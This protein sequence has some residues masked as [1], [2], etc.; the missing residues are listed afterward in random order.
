MT[1]FTEI[2]PAEIRHNPFQLIGREWMLITAGTI[3]GFNTMTAN[4][5]TWGYL[6]NRDVD[7]LLCAP[8][9]PHVRIHGA[10]R[11]VH[12][13]LL[14]GGVAEGAGVLRSHSGRDVDKTGADGADPIRDAGRRG[15]A[16]SRRGWCWSAG[17]CMR[18]T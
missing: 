6:W 14:R 4:W 10:E 7:D 15:R 9:A 11:R 1:H 2:A 3:D 8:A 13:E 18:G 16:S 17:S 12:A 5:G